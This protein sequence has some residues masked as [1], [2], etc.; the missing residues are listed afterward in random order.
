[1]VMRPVHAIQG[2]LDPHPIA[3]PSVSSTQNVQPTKLASK[4]NVVIHASDP[5]E[6]MPSAMWS[7][8]MPFVLAL[9]DTLVILSLSVLYDHPLLNHKK[10]KI[11]VVLTLV[12]PILIA[13]EGTRLQHVNANQTT[14]VTPILDVNRN[15]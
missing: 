13:N 5:A 15:V 8:T 12:D 6:S 1:M 10:M 14:L 11:L 4:E 3:D 9:R 2:T 7:T